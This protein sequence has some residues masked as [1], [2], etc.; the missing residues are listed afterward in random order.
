MG[1]ITLTSTRCYMVLTQLSDSFPHLLGLWNHQVLNFTHPVCYVL[2]TILIEKSTSW[3][4]GA[5]SQTLRLSAVNVFSLY[6]LANCSV[7]LSALSFNL[8]HLLML[9]V[10]RLPFSFSPGFGHFHI[11]M[12][13][14]RKARQSDFQPVSPQHFISKIY[15]PFASSSHTSGCQVDDA[16]INW[17]WGPRRHA[18]VLC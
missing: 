9:T 12:N 2:S 6:S 1:D 13:C 5:R 10:S 15:N 18:L 11:I 17:A 8:L 16:C 4:E 14:D 7:I 3:Q